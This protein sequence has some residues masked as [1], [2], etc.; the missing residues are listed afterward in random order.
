MTAK[1]KRKKLW[2]FATAVAAAAAIGTGVWFGTQGGGEPVNVYPFQY[3]GMTEFWGDTQESYGPVSTDKIQTEF[4]S[5]TQTVTEVKVKD[6][7]TVKKGD[8]LFS[9]D[10][11]LDGLALERKRLDVEK[12]KFRSK[13]RKNGSRK[14]GSWCPMCLPEKPSRRR[15]KRIWVSS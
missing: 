8:V 12:I 9:F 7:D 3:I 10:T 5:E 11:T 15:K 14:P 2:L 4:L 1:K 13:P 6:G